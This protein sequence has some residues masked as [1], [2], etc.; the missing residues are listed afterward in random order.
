M[1]PPRTALALRSR[2]ALEEEAGYAAWM[3]GHY[4]VAV[5]YFIRSARHTLAARKLAKGG[6]DRG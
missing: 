2:A 1:T 3:L 5:R 4:S 6:D